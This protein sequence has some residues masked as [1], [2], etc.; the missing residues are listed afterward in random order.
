[1]ISLG[2][3]LVFVA[4]LVIVAVFLRVVYTFVSAG[5]QERRSEETRRQHPQGTRATASGSRESERIT[6]SQS[7][8]K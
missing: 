4:V 3:L 7:V 1:M 6:E 2:D 8:S 5:E